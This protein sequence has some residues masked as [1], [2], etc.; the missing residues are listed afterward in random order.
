MAWQQHE[1]FFSGE[2]IQQPVIYKAFG[3]ALSKICIIVD[4]VCLQVMYCF[5]NV[6]GRDNGWV[7]L[8]LDLGNTELISRFSLLF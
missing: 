4:T 2:N 3:F 8:D 6:W 5:I 7:A 1:C